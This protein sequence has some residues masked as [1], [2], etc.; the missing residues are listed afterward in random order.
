MLGAHLLICLMSPKQ[1]WSQGLV[2]QKPSC[3]LN[4][5][6]HGEPLFRLG[7]QGVEVLIPL[8]ALFLP[9]VAPESQQEF[10]LMDLMLYAFA[11]LALSWISG[12]F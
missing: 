3:F 1:V 7:V 8:S 5:T 11:L 2:A 6:W 4:V 10:L 12:Y 9:S